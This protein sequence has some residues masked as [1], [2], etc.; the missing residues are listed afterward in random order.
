MEDEA[1]EEKCVEEI[2][3]VNV[4][5]SLSVCVYVIGDCRGPNGFQK[6]SHNKHE[7]NQ[8][9]EIT[10]RSK[11]RTR[12]PP[13]GFAFLSSIQL[14]SWKIILIFLLYSVF[15]CIMAS[16]WGEIIQCW[17]D[18]ETEGLDRYLWSHM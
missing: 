6:E 16:S 18:T 17:N 7:G 13:A 12:N 3:G 1:W 11:N 5:V 8:T 9:V 14:H 2:V 4:R 15:N 10:T